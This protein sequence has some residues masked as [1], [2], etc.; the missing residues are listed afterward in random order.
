MYSPSTTADCQEV[1]NMDNYCYAQIMLSDSSFLFQALDKNTYYLRVLKMTYGS[2]SPDWA[3]YVAC[4]SS[5]WILGRS[6]ALTD[7]NRK[8]IYSLSVYG[9]TSKY[10]LFMMFNALDGSI[11][12]NR[13]TLILLY[14]W[15]YNL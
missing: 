14:S 10:L 3:Y 11:T 7:S 5:T 1:N 2:T 4:P 8:I 6:E 12:G 13:Y 15:F 9:D